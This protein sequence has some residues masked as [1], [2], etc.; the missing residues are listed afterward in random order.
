[1]KVSLFPA[2]PAWAI[3][4]SNWLIQLVHKFV[5]GFALISILLITLNWKQLPPLVPLWY[6]R[7]WGIDQLAKP[8]FLFLLPISSICIYLINTLLSMYVTAEYLIFTQSIFLSSLI[9]SI[10]SF[11]A[12]IKIIYLVI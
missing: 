6:S 1:M 4:K 2:L 5:I 10:V 7:P 12:V 8:I 11:I 3:T 9:V